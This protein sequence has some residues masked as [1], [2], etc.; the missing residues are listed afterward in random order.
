M[1][2]TEKI[3]KLHAR[4]Q[5][6]GR[7]VEQPNTFSRLVNACRDLG[8]VGCDNQSHVKGSGTHVP[9]YLETLSAHL[10]TPRHGNKV[11]LSFV[12][13][14]SHIYNFLAGSENLATDHAS[15]V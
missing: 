2:N 10:P 15:L 7:R 14:H 5:S 1:P 9:H 6:G 13:I 4:M 8:Q 11:R 3:T 12:D